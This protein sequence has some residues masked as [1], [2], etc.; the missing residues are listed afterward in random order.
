MNVLSIKKGFLDLV[1]PLLTLEDHPPRSPQPSFA[2]EEISSQ[3]IHLNV[4][5]RYAFFISLFGIFL[6][7]T[8]PR[9]SMADSQRIEIEFKRKTLSAH[10]R[11]ARLISVIEAIREKRGIWFKSWLKGKE[12]VLEEKISIQLNEVPIKQGL[13]RILSNINHCLVFDG[14]GY[15]LGVFLLGEPE[16]TKYRGRTP[17]TR[18]ST[19]RRSYPRR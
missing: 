13:G 7:L 6:I 16:K 8:S 19:S 14:K 4:R 9:N 5:K 15:L 2:K 18:R 11:N 12:A 1:K 17:S 3:I 10:I